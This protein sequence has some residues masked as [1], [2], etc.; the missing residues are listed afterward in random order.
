MINVYLWFILEQKI[1]HYS[2]SQ[3]AKEYKGHYLDWL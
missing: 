1:K 2:S 3:F